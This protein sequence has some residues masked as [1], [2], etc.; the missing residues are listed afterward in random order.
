MISN[1]GII[2]LPI[3]ILF[4]LLIALPASSLKVGSHRA[5]NEHIAQNNTV[6]FSLDD[7]L[8]G[9]LGLTMGADQD[10]DCQGIDVI[11]CNTGGVICVLLFQ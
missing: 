4:I 8:K 6:G 9:N 3:I 7:Y 1:R 10:I 2:F 11:H 5:I